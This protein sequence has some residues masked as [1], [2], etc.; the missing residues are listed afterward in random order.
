MN[1]YCAT[2]SQN[3]KIFKIATAYTQYNTRLYIL[4]KRGQVR[5]QTLDFTS[6]WT[7]LVSWDFRRSFTGD[8][9]GLVVVGGL[10]WMLVSTTSWFPN[11][12]NSGCWVAGSEGWWVCFWRRFSSWRTFCCCC[13]KHCLTKYQFLHDWVTIST[14]IWLPSHACPV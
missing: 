8:E 13:C 1:S 6:G 5:I 7:C 12:L 11:R 4:W 9:T 2:N 14:S 3:S 10:V